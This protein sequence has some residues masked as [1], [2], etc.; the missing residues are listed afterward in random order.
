M[1]STKFALCLQTTVVPFG[2]LMA[3]GAVKKNRD[4]PKYKRYFADGLRAVTAAE[5]REEEP[6]IVA[7]ILESM[8]EDEND[9]E[10]G[11][12]VT[13]WKSKLAAARAKVIATV[14]SLETTEKA[15]AYIKDKKLPVLMATWREEYKKLE[16]ALLT[17]YASN[18]KRVA[19]F[20]K[21]FRKNRKV[22][23]LQTPV[24]PP[25]SP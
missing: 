3:S 9:P 22:S 15:I 6:K 21:P 12:V 5:S 24:V 8:A 25:A 13:Q 18:P 17:V 4:N 19:R 10:I 7:D 16:G 14:E 1:K 2:I 20:F 23:K 11:A